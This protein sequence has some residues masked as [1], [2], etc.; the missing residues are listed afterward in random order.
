MP[1]RYTGHA[2]E[3][4]A[5]DLISSAQGAVECA[6]EADKAAMALLN[7]ASEVQPFLKV[8]TCPW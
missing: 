3:L 5:V 6:E 1:S 4:A 7:G 2:G 8:D